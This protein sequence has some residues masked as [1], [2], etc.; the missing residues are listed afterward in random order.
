MILVV[1]CNKCS[2]SRRF[3]VGLC[4][5]RFRCPNCRRGVLK[6]PMDSSSG[7]LAGQDSASSSGDDEGSGR[8][9]ECEDCGTLIKA[10][11]S[12]RKTRL[13]C[14]DC[15]K[16]R[17]FSESSMK[18]AAPEASALPSPK[19]RP[20]PAAKRFHFVSFI[21]GALLSG[22][23]VFTFT[24][25][26]P[27]TVNADHKPPE[28]PIERPIERPV[29]RPV[30]RPIE[31][32]VER[33][34]E[35]PPAKATGLV[36]TARGPAQRARPEDFLMEGKVFTVDEVVDGDTMHI[37]ELPNRAKVRLLGVDTPETKHVRKGVE[38]WGPE[39]STFTKKMLNNK[40]VVLR[41]DLDNQYGVFGRPLV[42][43]ELLDGRDFNALLIKE[44]YAR[45]TREYPFNRQKEYEAYE[46]EAKRIGKG[47][48]DSAGRA[49]FDAAKRAKAE[50]AR[51]A[52]A[53]AEK[54]EARERQQ[55]INA[56]IAE[57]GRYIKGRR[58]KTIHEPWC[59]R[60]PGKDVEHH[61]GI[62]ALISEGC[63]RHSC[64]EKP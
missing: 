33:P 54:A 29:E 58:S 4:G 51:K 5:R 48:W 1:K 61:K 56:A 43:I 10:D 23:A 35:R 20:A 36:E 2:Y 53:A 32:P 12:A 31:R 44:G 26:G 19:P 17:A 47:M 25:K 49:E 11:K 18:L 63:K 15:R 55:A 3:A 38:F 21:V 9:F 57:G 40:Q 41:I 39:A 37:A 24:G 14:P 60:K 7:R 64:F 45:C 28:R 27:E 59:S 42:Y 8:L 6:V 30:E 46:D 50:A 34:R 52:S 22:L 16:E 62:E 13:R